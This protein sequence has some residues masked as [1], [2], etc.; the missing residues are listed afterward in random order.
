MG[1]APATLIMALA[2]A[3]AYGPTKYKVTSNG[4][5]IPG[6]MGSRGQHCCKVCGWRFHK[7]SIYSN[8]IRIHTNTKPF[9]CL[10]CNKA[11]RQNTTLTRHYKSAR[12]LARGHVNISFFDERVLRCGDCSQAFTHGNELLHHRKLMH[13]FNCG[14]TTCLRCGRPY[15]SIT[16][17]THQCSRII[18]CKCN[19][20]G[21]TFTQWK[22]LREH[23]AVH[24]GER[25][26]QCPGCLRN[27]SFRS[28]L[29][30]HRKTKACG[31]RKARGN[32]PAQKKPAVGLVN[33]KL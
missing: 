20:C 10:Q 22:G 23:E 31:R 17:S 32:L 29:F 26:F 24:T 4:S 2:L 1:R 3:L 27:F 7:L 33:V 13:P 19:E 16:N 14:L 21:R 9:V 6:P 5:K 25:I 12:H 30:R 18:R 11:F 28:S 8:H 15:F